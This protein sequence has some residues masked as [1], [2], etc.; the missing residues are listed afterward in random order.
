[1]YLPYSPAYKMNLF[2]SLRNSFKKR[3][4]SYI[5]KV[6]VVWLF[7]KECAPCAY[8]GFPLGGCS[9]KNIRCPF[10][11]YK[12]AITKSPYHGDLYLTDSF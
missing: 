3:G 10:S 1:M 4:A 8:A 2:L 6:K 5:K 7:Q 11:F 9:L 12:S